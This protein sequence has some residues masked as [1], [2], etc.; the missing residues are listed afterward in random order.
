[1]F[2]TIY[3]VT[4]GV[5]LTGERGPQDNISRA[6]IAASGPTSAVVLA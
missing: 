6:A 1:M 5:W 3:E 2:S 4:S